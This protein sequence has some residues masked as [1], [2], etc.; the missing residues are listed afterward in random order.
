M[1]DI[2]PTARWANRMLRPLTS[3]YH[4]L[5]KHH[6]I[7]ASVTDAKTRANAGNTYP[8]RVDVPTK[9]SAQSVTDQGCTYPDDEPDDPA[10]IPGRPPSRR[11]RH[12][13]SSRG[14][15]N[16]ARRRT[17]LSIPSPE[18]QRTL[19]GAIE[20]ATPLITGRSHGS[21]DTSSSIRKQ[22]FRNAM[23]TLNDGQASDNRKGTR[24][25]N[26]SFPAYQGSWKEVLDICGD[27]GFVDIARYLDHV[28]LKF[29]N[30]TRD[31]PTVIPQQ[32]HTTL[33]T[34]GPRSLMSMALRRLPDFVAQERILQDEYEDDGDLNM[35][36]A[37]FT[38]L[39]SHYASHGSGWQPLRE[40]ARAQGIYLISEMIQ[41][42]WIPRLAACRLLRVCLEHDEFDAFESL[43]SRCLLDIPTY[44]YP[45]AF[46]TP[47]ATNHREDPI[48]VLRA[49][50]S[51]VPSR[52]YFFFD[53]LAK[54]LTR[55]VLPPEWMVTN[56]WKKCVDGAIQSVSTGDGN[57]A[58]ATKVVEAII[59]AS[60]GI[61]LDMGTVLARV[62]DSPRQ[63][64]PTSAKD[65]RA[66]TKNTTSLLEGRAPCPVPIQDALSNL[67]SSL[68]TALCGMCIAR[69]QASGLDERISGLKVRQ[70][71]EQFAFR[72]Q[73][74]IG[75]ASTPGEIPV[76]GLQ[77]LRRGYVLLGEF[78]L[79]A[80]DNIPYDDL[81]AHFG[82]VSEQNIDAF[83]VLLAGQHE[84]IKE[85]AEFARQVFH[86]CGHA[87]KSEPTRTPRAIKDTVSRLARVTSLTGASLLLD[88]VAAETAMM[89]AE[90]TLDA[91]DHAWALEM[92]GEAIS[93]QREHRAMR[94]PT[95]Q[96]APA[97]EIN[98]TYRWEDTI[99]EWVVKTPASKP[100]PARPKFALKAAC[101]MSSSASPSSAPSEA[102]ASSVTSSA[103]SLAG[104]RGCTQQ[105]P[106]LRSPKRLRSASLKLTRETSGA[107][108]KDS[109]RVGESDSAPVAARTRTA[110]RDLSQAKNRVIQSSQPGGSATSKRVT[111]VQPP[112]RIEVVIVNRHT[113]AVDR[114]GIPSD[115]VLACR[116]S[117]RL[118]RASISPLACAA[119]TS[120][121]TESTPR[122]SRP[123]GA[124]RPPVVI[125][126]SD[127][128]S[129]D[130]LSFLA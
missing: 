129:D 76:P 83:W 102:M 119:T 65:T 22:L 92:Q 6:E 21:L 43:L 49:Y 89:L 4:R 106:G 117:A 116:K 101:S 47:Q 104:K 113:P 79:R 40:A 109:E 3:I 59:L 5:E 72:V 87:R 45:L 48:R 100:L 39:E 75:I 86:C 2:R 64:H 123:R 30:N 33:T 77:L 50:Y 78:I 127:E 74:A 108:R 121:A 37:Y 103:P 62:E 46:D 14:Q 15:R 67:T 23:S 16:G 7:R 93:S 88:Q 95:S 60:A 27:P 126:F 8:E 125:S 38:E 118:A 124:Q 56:L 20:I 91:D 73:R 111:P 17:R 110:L 31:A 58:A 1:E 94:P 130:E 51:R 114:T 80:S 41:R 98:D 25:S 53:E 61:S 34:R 9:R 105:S 122:P 115:A 54:L 32:E 42:G 28:L 18:T 81:M 71:V 63:Q 52:R 55:G 99:G 85:L 97:A 82:T 12:N 112:P 13:Y 96:G 68:V 120:V 11:I 128:D 29:L 26:S 107:T 66:S 90:I 57:H 10:W 35:C 69:T 44:E 84:I 19:P 70:V 36:D 24:T